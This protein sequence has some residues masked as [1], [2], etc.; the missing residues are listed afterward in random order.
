AF[1]DRAE[2]YHSCNL[3][4]ERGASSKQQQRCSPIT[5]YLS[6]IL[7]VGTVCR[8]LNSSNP[9]VP[10]NKLRLCLFA[11]KWGLQS[12]PRLR[13]FAMGRRES[14]GTSCTNLG[15]PEQT[16]IYLFAMGRRE[17]GGT[18]CFQ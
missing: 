7:S 16:K 6:P 9:W 11:K 5:N 3:V 13:L 18:S 12:K 2:R 14:G 17:S 1:N 15:P 4:T 10:K 8:P